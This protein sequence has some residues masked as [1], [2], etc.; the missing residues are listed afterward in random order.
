[1]Q[2]G[3][4]A[5]V[6][7]SPTSGADHQAIHCNKLNHHVG[8]V[9][10]SL[11]GISARQLHPHWDSAVWGAET[12]YHAHEQRNDLECVYILAR[13]EAVWPVCQPILY[14]LNVPYRFQ[15]EAVQVESPLLLVEC[16]QPASAALVP[17]VLPHRLNF[18]LGHGCKLSTRMQTQHHSCGLT[19]S[20]G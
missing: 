9:T 4:S 19:G 15:P 11:T 6:L 16:D 18:I 10:Q 13:Y 2:T 1:M 8:V 14:G 7:N 3:T 17:L 20:V 5:H 12:G